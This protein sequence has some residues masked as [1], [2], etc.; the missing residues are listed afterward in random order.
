M[1]EVYLLRVIISAE[2]YH[3]KFKVVRV[4]AFA[5]FHGGLVCTQRWILV[6]HVVS[7]AV[8]YLELLLQS[9]NRHPII[10]IEV[11]LK[12]HICVVI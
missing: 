7:I 2:R 12:F 6:T 10:G 3:T 9:I 1:V 11:L 8:K 5:N 4:H